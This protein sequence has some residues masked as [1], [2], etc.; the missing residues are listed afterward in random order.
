VGWSI[1]GKDSDRFAG[2]GSALER[3]ASRFRGSRSTRPFTAPTLRDLAEMGRQ[4]PRRFPVRGQDSGED[5]PPA[6]AGRLLRS[7]PRLVAEEGGLGDKLGVLLLQ[8]PSRL[9]FDASLVG[10]FLDESLPLI[11][12]HPVCEPRHPSWFDE[13]AQALL[14]TREIARV[15]AHPAC[16]P[17]AL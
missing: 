13:P 6:Q 11:R 14:A 17:A 3:Y 2:A 10:A 15:A 9:A 4:S 16:V 1:P 5:H 7:A 12:A 8:L